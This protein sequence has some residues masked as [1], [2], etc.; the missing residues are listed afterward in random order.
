MI[1]NSSRNNLDYIVKGDENYNP[2]LEQ[3][4]SGNYT[5]TNYNKEDRDKIENL[6]LIERDISII[7]EKYTSQQETTNTIPSIYELLFNFIMEDGEGDK[8]DIV[9]NF[10]NH[11]NSLNKFR[12]NAKDYQG[13]NPLHWA[14]EISSSEAWIAFRN[15]LDQAEYPAPLSERNHFEETPWSIVFQ[16][17]DLEFVGDVLFDEIT[18]N[19]DSTIIKDLIKQHGNDVK[20]YKNNIEFVFK[21]M[22]HRAILAGDIS[23]IK[24]C[25]DE[26]YQKWKLLKENK[27]TGYDYVMNTSEY[28]SILKGFL[29]SLDTNIFLQHSNNSI[30]N[31]I[32]NALNNPNYTVEDPLLSNLI[33]YFREEYSYSKEYKLNETKHS[34][35]I[36]YFMH[37][38]E[39]LLFLN[40]IINGGNVEALNFLDKTSNHYSIKELLEDKLADKRKVTSCICSIFKQKDAYRCFIGLG[41]SKNDIFKLAEKYIFEISQSGALA[42]T[43]DIL[44]ANIG[45]NGKEIETFLSTRNTNGET[46]LYTAA[47]EDHLGSTLRDIINVGISTKQILTLLSTPDKYG[48]TLFHTAAYLGYLIKNLFVIKQEGF[49]IKQILI[50]LSL[51]NDKGEVSLHYAAYH[52]NLGLTLK[53]MRQVGISSEE[54][55]TLLSI[56]GDDGYTSLRTASFIGSLGPT[57]RDMKQVDLSPEQIFILLSIANKAGKT[58]LFGQEKNTEVS[59]A[60]EEIGLSQE[61]ISPLYSQQKGN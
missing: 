31:H 53:G 4:L 51:T 46:L 26:A 23:V 60:L 47:N 34:Y 41:Y 32:K 19:P 57:L 14:A 18:R 37:T 12:F 59:K 15:I 40:K 58:S 25:R 6:D 24:E 48:K 8:T 38:P 39:Y 44:I 7:N 17:K 36:K 1:N 29:E 5:Y 56:Q 28:Q 43:L 13:H 49:S 10:I 61:Q 2:N 52:H 11:F 9:L 33:N 35:Q 21:Y 50:L 55:F 27:E 45:L 30:K 3:A 22:E 16:S 42:N 54:I 20:D